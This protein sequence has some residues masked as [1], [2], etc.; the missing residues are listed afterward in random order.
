[1]H[2]Y[3][4]RALTQRSLAQ[5]QARYILRGCNLDN[6]RRLQTSTACRTRRERRFDPAD[7]VIDK[8]NASAGVA[9]AVQG[10]CALQIG[11][12]SIGQRSCDGI[13]R[14]C[15]K[16]RL[17]QFTQSI[18]LPQAVHDLLHQD[19]FRVSKYHHSCRGQS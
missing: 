7:P 3:P 9:Y 16:G 14:K 1:M 18:R 6:C 19:L 15:P 17:R 10:P 8:L 13:R 5:L 12:Q 4:N 2:Q 11:V